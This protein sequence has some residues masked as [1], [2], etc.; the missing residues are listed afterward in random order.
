MKII[1]HI[2]EGS[3]ESNLIRLV[4]A[5]ETLEV[6]MNLERQCGH[7][8]KYETRL[9]NKVVKR[10]KSR[11]SCTYKDNIVGLEQELDEILD[12]FFSLVFLV[13]EVLNLTFS[14]KFKHG[15]FLVQNFLF[16]M[17]ILIK[18]RK[19]AAKPCSCLN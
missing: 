11:I 15:V 3:T 13:C 14:F 12:G 4:R 19:R 2:L 7:M 18:R 17:K 9:K 10:E 5:K 8:I 1:L 16:S 6:C